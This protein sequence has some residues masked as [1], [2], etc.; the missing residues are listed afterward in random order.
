MFNFTVP[1]EENRI[2]RGWKKWLKSEWELFR[3]VEKRWGKHSLCLRMCCVSGAALAGLQGKK[4][5]LVR[6]GCYKKDHRLGGLNHKHL[7]LTALEAGKSEI[8]VLADAAL[9][10]ACFPVCKK[11]SSLHIS[12]LLKP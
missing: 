8:K 7:L 4:P 10:R 3:W 5:I 6:Q 2:S 1:P 9:V 11:A 12:F